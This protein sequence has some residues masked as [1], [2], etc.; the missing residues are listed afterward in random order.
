MQRSSETLTFPI[1]LPLLPVLWVWPV[2]AGAEA[3]NSAPLPAASLVGIAP[4]AVVAALA[5][6]VAGLRLAPGLRAAVRRWWPPFRRLS[7]AV[8]VLALGRWAARHDG[9]NPQG[10]VVHLV[11]LPGLEAVQLALWLH[12]EGAAALADASRGPRL[13]ASRSRIQAVAGSGWKRHRRSGP[14]MTLR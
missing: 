1:L 9:R 4:L 10:A 11:L 7:P 8:A 13:Q 6:I 12:R 14:A 5:A 3:R 2:A